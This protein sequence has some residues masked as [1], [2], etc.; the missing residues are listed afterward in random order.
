M[1]HVTKKAGGRNAFAKVHLIPLKSKPNSIV[2][3]W[4]MADGASRQ[5]TSTFHF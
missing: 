3:S 4:R 5:L 2:A 1:A